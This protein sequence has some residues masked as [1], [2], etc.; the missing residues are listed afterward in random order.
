VPSPTLRR[1]VPRP[2]P[3]PSAHARRQV[4]SRRCWAASRS[5]NCQRVFDL[6]IEQL[7]AQISAAADRAMAQPHLY[8]ELLLA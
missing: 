6:P 2:S 3:T 4:L 8:A 5:G 1:S 7:C